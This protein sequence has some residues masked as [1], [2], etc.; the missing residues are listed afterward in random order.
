M[1]E[2]DLTEFFSVLKHGGYTHGISVE[3]YGSADKK[4]D[5]ETAIAVLRKTWDAI[6]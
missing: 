6:D 1:Q 5:A 3:C 2:W 4:L